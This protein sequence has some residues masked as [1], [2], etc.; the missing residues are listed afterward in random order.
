MQILVLDESYCNQVISLIRKTD[1][2]INWSDKQIFESFND[3]GL[4]F[5]ILQNG[6]LKGV[7][8]FN[9]ILDVAELLYI[10]V[11]KNNQSAGLGYQLLEA[12]IQELKLKG[13]KEF[14]LEVDVKNSNAIKLYK[15][16]GFKYIS[17]RKNYYVYKDGNTSDALI[18]KL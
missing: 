11:G 10:C 8:I 6:Q 2:Y 5:G 1:D 15:K 13:I 7:S 16:V 3:N 12:S 17:T 14:F 18:Y 4:V 9:Y